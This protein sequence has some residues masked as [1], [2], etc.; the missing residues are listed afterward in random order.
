M[1]LTAEQLLEVRRAIGATEP[2]STDD[3]ETLHDT[4]GSVEAVV[5]QVLSE[6][7]AAMR[8]RPLEVDYQGDVTE[9]WGNNLKALEKAVEAAAAAAG[10]PGVISTGQLVRR[11]R[12][13]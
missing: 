11:G 1:A 4:L 9:R 12:R 2:P 8:E 7:L 10:G 13:R 3:L 5:Y 6:R